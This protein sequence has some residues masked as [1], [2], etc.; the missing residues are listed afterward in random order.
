MHPIVNL[1]KML[2]NVGRPTP[3]RPL[4]CLVCQPP[5]STAAESGT[6]VYFPPDV[7]GDSFFWVDKPRIPKD[8][9]SL[10]PEAPVKE[11]N[12]QYE[13]DSEVPQYDRGTNGPIDSESER[14]NGAGDGVYLWI[15]K[16][17]PRC[18]NC[19]SYTHAARDCP[20]PRDH[21]GKICF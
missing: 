21:Q 4:Y 13:Q 19:G 17:A 16:D 15:E 1:H 3:L 6:V 14:E 5:S 12:S 10:D 9:L 8:S 2:Q 11:F 20:K 7:G 18:W